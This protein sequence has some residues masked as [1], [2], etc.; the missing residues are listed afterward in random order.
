MSDLHVNSWITGAEPVPIEVG[1]VAPLN[2]QGIIFRSLSRV[3]GAVNSAPYYNPNAKGI[4][5]WVANDA[6]GGSTV[7]VKIQVL[8]PADGVTWVDLAGATSGTINS[9]TGTITT[10]YPGLTGIADAAGVTI[11]QHLG[12]MWRMVITT[13]VATGTSSVGAEY[14]L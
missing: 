10:V 4:R 1:G 8:N 11:N 12:T 5:F 6:A 9:S 13:A 14:L 7:V 3:V 2:R